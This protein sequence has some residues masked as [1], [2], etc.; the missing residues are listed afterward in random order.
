MKPIDVSATESYDFLCRSMNATVKVQVKGTR[1]AGTCC[2][3]RMAARDRQ[4]GLG[5]APASSLPWD[6]LC[7]VGRAAQLRLAKEYGA[8][9]AIC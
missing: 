8:R 6:G 9:H 1:G 3:F 5:P 7:R 4:G 2:A